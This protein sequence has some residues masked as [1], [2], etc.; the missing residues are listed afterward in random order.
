MS[1]TTKTIKIAPA[2]FA[3]NH[4]YQIMMYTD[5]QCLMWVKVGDKTYYDEDNGILRS[6]TKVHRV[7]VP[8]EE[9]DAAKSYTVC[10]RYIINRKKP[11]RNH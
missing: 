7:I 9:L 4:D 6:C 8:M 1:E 5:D 2:V 10:L 11:K 3:V